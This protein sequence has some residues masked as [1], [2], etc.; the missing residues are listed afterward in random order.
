MY[1][2]RI[3]FDETPFFDVLAFFQR[4]QQSKQ[5]GDFNKI[6]QSKSVA[7]LFFEPSTRTRLSFERALHHL[8]VPYL[9]LSG[10]QGSS[11]EKGESLEDTCRNIEAMRP[12]LMVLRVPET[13]DLRQWKS[14]CQVPFICAG[15][16]QQAHPTQALLDAYTLWEKWGELKGKRLLVMGDLK[17][18]RVLASWRQLGSLVGIELGYWAPIEAHLPSFNANEKIFT[19]KVDALGWA[20]GVIGLRWQKERHAPGVFIETDLQ[21]QL[22]LADLVHFDSQRW[23]LHPG[24]I[25]W[26][27]EFSRDLRSS[28]R[29]CI[30]EQ[31]HNGVWVRAQWIYELLTG[32]PQN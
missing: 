11:I 20:D 12:N 31:V 16:G 7:L 18:S 24:P 21:Y 13:F 25:G 30:M 2:N 23:V 6:A 4:V 9:G 19:N 3:Q 8:G 1:H 32:S 17:H 15:W 27:E 22:R 28:D 14:S 10:A 29:L 26:G 5:R